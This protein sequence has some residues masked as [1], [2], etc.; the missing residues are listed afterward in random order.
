MKILK[1]NISLSRWLMLFTGGIAALLFTM[2][3]HTSGWLLVV[4]A[5][6]F[7]LGI[8]NFARQCP[9]LLS[10]H[11]IRARLQKKNIP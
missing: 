4:A 1:S 11:S 3:I 7:T 5:T 9:L 6:G 8:T 2:R 10:F